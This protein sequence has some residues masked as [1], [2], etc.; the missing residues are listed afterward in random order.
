MLRSQGL[1]HCRAVTR[2]DDLV[3]TIHRTPPDFIAVADT[4]DDEIFHRMRDVRHHRIGVNP[5]IVITFMV[6]PDNDKA[7]KRAVLAGA[8]DVMIKPIAPGKIV[9]RA[10]KI[11][12]HRSPFIATTDYIGPDR[13]Q[14]NRK[15]VIPLLEVI[16]TL[17]DKM[18]GNKVTMVALK[19]MVEKN[20]KSVRSAQLDS[21]GLRLGYVCNLILKA[22]DE[23]KVTSKVK[24][25]LLTLVHCL[26]EAGKS[27]KIIGERELADI[28]TTFARQVEELAEDYQNPT[29]RGLG[30][31]RKL[32]KAF[33]MAKGAAKSPDNQAA[34]APSPQGAQ[35]V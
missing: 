35:P 12:Y 29:D 19:S 34:P 17:R 13:R 18:E 6:D 25:N 22:Y 31:I 33:A 2:L 9:E 20:M 27:A 14:D 4:F 11:A 15:S 24:D 3:E 28:C 23:K 32:T 16:N 1:R 21:H 8:D 30:L 10:K 26:E 7:M 5:F